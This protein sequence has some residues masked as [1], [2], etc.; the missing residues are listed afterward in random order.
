MFNPTEKDE[1]LYLKEIIDKLEDAYIAIDERVNREHKELQ[2]QKTYLYENKTGMDAAEKASIKQSVNMQAISGEAAAAYKIRL[3]KLISRPYFGRIDFREENEQEGEPVYVGIHSFVNEDD[4]KPLIHDWRAPVSSLFYDFE[5]GSAS[6][7]TPNGTREGEI[8]RKRQFRITNGEMEMMLESGLYIRDDVLQKELSRSA[9]DKMKNIVATIQ[10]DQNAII[11]NETSPVLIIQGVAGSGKTSIALHRIAFLLYRF[12]DTLSS[13]DI[14]IIS[15]N[16][17][18]SDY[19]S[20][21]LPELGEETIPEMEMEELANRV[22]GDK[23]KFEGFFNQV[24]KLLEDHDEEYIKRIEFKAT[25]EFLSKLNTYSSW[26]KRNRFQPHEI[27]VRFKTVSVQYLRQRYNANNQLP[28][29]RRHT[30]IASDI[31]KKAKREFKYM[32]KPEEKKEIRKQVKQMMG[33]D[34]LRV[35]YKGFYEWIERPEMFQYAKGSIF[36]FSDLFPLVYLKMQMDGADTMQNVK[37][38]IVDEMQDYTAVQ[39]AVLSK[40]FPCNK[41]ILGDANQNVNPY[42]STTAKDIGEIFTESESV[43]LNTTYRS[44]RE[45]VEFT[46]RI[47][48]NVV[49][50]PIE[51]HGEKP[52]V[53]GF[54]SGITEKKTILKLAE[55][56]RASDDQTLGILCKTQKQAKKLHNYLKKHL[57]ELHLLSPEE[58]ALFSGIV[59]TSS[60]LAKGL[61]FDRVIVPHVTTENYQTDVDRSMLYIACTR[62]MHWLVLTYAGE[63]TPLIG[64]NK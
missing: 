5:P 2:E 22:L 45:I 35:L 60:H 40:L 50:D 56:F 23:F 1:R 29:M 63:L 26:M 36:E 11:R 3:Q 16:K 28:L 46:K 47:S 55:E 4:S 31:I 14:M 17:V 21:V 15:P 51:R 59:I 9:D 10:R 27:K 8:E 30:A 54:E 61:E 20:N 33:S 18:F 58:S 57:D 39:Y 53:L 43:T 12:K 25:P 38:L 49:A 19:I 62:A 41:T 6:F 48:S 32:L 44:T 52:E 37:H 34:N 7:E 24:Q 13:R 64:G 42:S